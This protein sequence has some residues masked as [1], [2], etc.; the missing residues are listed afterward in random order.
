MATME[1]I[2]GTYPESK[3]AGKGL[4]MAGYISANQLNNIDKAKSLYE[5]YLARYAQSDSTLTAMVRF[6]LENLGKSAEQILLE[7]QQKNAAQIAAE[8][9]AEEP[10]EDPEVLKAQNGT[11]PSP[12][13]PM[14]AK[15][16]K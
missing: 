7:M 9:Q 5:K 11:R 6:E 3:F 8:S 4:F 16:G 13:A 2:A 10:L 15:K 14:P 1:S 12:H